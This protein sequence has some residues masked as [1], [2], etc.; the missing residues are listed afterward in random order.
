[1]S[2]FFPWLDSSA[3]PNLAPQNLTQSILPGMSLITVNETN[4]PAPDAEQ[5]IVAQVS[6]GRQIGKLLEAMVALIPESE[7]KK[8][9]FADILALQTQVEAAKAEARE[10]RLKRLAADLKALKAIDPEA[11]STLVKDI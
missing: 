7:R 9:A 3:W 8:Q 5:R 2:A 11:F 6:Y 10:E 1:M 4:S